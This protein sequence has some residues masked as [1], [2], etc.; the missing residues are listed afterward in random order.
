MA[1]F[2]RG[3]LQ[4]R[5]SKALRRELSEGDHAKIEDLREQ[6]VK[7]GVD[8][9]LAELVASELASLH[10]G[11]ER[12]SGEAQRQ[13][14]GRDFGIAVFAVLLT[15]SGAVGIL[16]P[17]VGA[18]SSGFEALLGGIVVALLLWRQFNDSRPMWI[19][20]RYLAEHARTASFASLGGVNCAQLVHRTLSALPAER[21]SPAWLREELGQRLL[22]IESLLSS[23]GTQ[24]QLAP[25]VAEFLGRVWVQ[26]QQD[27]HWANHRRKRIRAI[28]SSVL[29]LFALTIV[30]AIALLQLDAA[31]HPGVQRFGREFALLSVVLPGVASAA[32]LFSS[33]Y[34]LSRVA[35]RSL[36]MHHHWRGCARKLSS[37]ADDAARSSQLSEIA[38]AAMLENYEWSVLL[39]TAE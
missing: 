4:S 12:I 7:G 31:L 29:G 9:Q 24:G 28:L 35:G 36:Q 26:D 19:C 11:C 13:S 17:S 10:L 21:N 8:S 37:A 2:Q 32:F 25:K 15:L 27:W 6:A 33:Q 5:F 30:T 18:W 14:M 38:E 23:S 34:E 22:R 20:A 39:G 16:Y 3:T 1:I